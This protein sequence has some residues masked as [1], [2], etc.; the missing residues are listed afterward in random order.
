MTV[1]THK[2]W[3]MSDLS[4]PASNIDDDGQV[5]LEMYV[6]CQEFNF[7]FCKESQFANSNPYKFEMFGLKNSSIFSGIVDTFL[8]KSL[9]FEI[10]EQKY[11]QK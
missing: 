11:L 10:C 6:I 8:Q 9:L 2:M 3:A 4:A 1:S 5:K 7:K